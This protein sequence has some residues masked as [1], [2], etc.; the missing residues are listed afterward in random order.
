MYF[1][2]QPGGA[3]VYTYGSG[4]RGAQLVYPNSRNYA[5]DSEIEFW[6]YDPTDKGGSYTGQAACS[7]IADRSSPRPVC[8]HLRVHR[9]NDQRRMDTASDRKSLPAPKDGDTVDLG[10]GLFVMEKT[11]LRLPDIRSV[12]ADSDVPSGRF[13]ITPV[14]HW[15]FS[16][17]RNLPLVR[18]GR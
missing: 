16:P 4:P 1:T 8:R 10:T 6:H 17:I 7:L 3:Y 18:T 9:C 2:I 11:D 14:R 12:D 5:T 15:L 13:T